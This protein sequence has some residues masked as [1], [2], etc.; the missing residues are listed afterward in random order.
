[1]VGVVASQMF[2]KPIVFC[3]KCFYIVGHVFFD[4]V[5]CKHLKNCLPVTGLTKGIACKS[6]R[7]YKLNHTWD[8][9]FESESTREETSA[10]VLVSHDG[11]V[12]EAGRVECDLPRV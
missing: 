11:E 10:G 7:L 4:I 9:S 6:L 3:T 1:M 12:G 2:L 5:F 8:T